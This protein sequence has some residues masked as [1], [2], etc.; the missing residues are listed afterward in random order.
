MATQSCPVCN[1][2]Y[3]FWERL[4]QPSMCSSCWQAKKDLPDEGAIP[5]QGGQ[6]EGAQ[7]SAFEDEIHGSFAT[8]L[9]AGFFGGCIGVLLVHAFGG[10]PRTLNGA[11]VGF[12]AQAVIGVLLQVVAAAQ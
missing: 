4:S 7:P 10:K 6:S 5:W 12:V 9:F 2:P 8:G 3:G 1:A 11:W